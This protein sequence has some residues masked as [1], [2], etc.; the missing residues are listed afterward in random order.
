[1]TGPTRKV[2]HFARPAALPSPV[3]YAAQT[4]HSCHQPQGSS[5]FS[6]NFEAG[7]PI[8]P[9]F[10]TRKAL[11][12]ALLSWVTIIRGIVSQM[13]RQNHRELG[14]RCH[15]AAGEAITAHSPRGSGRSGLEGAR[16]LDFQSRNVV[17]TLRLV[18]EM[19]GPG[20][21]HEARVIFNLSRQ[22]KKR[23]QKSAVWIQAAQEGQNGQTG[24]QN[25][26]ADELYGSTTPQMPQ[27]VHPQILRRATNARLAIKGLFPHNY[28]HT[29]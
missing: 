18:T 2:G 24:G 25:P 29:Y 22:T 27:S 3:H 21:S 28:P 15:G 11:W 17:A 7:R 10:R 6:L 8:S 23:G 4:Q 12:S 14:H 26:I 20:L 1:M 9:V 19:L 5:P 16:F 13:I